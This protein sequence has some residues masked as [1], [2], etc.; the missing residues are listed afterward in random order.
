MSSIRKVASLA[1]VSVA[2]VS[3]ALSSPEKVS[4]KSLEKVQVAIEQ[5][6]YRPNMLAR[7]F[8]SARAYSIL[9]LIPDISNPFFSEVVRS[10]EDHAQR[11]GYG[12]LL[13]DTQDSK[14]KEQ[15]YITM[16]ETR[17]ADGVIQLR[18]D[19]P[20]PTSERDHISCVNAC[21][22][23]DTPEPVIRIDNVAAAKTLV[24]YLISLGH[25]RIGVI[26]GLAKNPHTKDRFAGYLQSLE[27]AGIEFDGSLVAEGDFT[28]WSGVNSADHFCRM[29]QRPTALFCMN[30]E[31]A[32]GAMQTLKSYNIDVPKEMSVT[33]FDDIKN[34]KYYN[35]S[36]TTIAQPAEE[37]G[38]VAVDTL[39]RII[40]GETLSETQIVLPFEFIVRNSTRP[41]KRF[42]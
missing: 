25:R 28:M 21:G 11:R 37:I 1:G 34:A 7:N 40:E 26:T 42:V 2:T 23:E 29:E 16:V 31:M 35:P 41:I 5:L 14:T 32:L 36:L 22:S 27:E 20:L 3:R 8:R 18:P 19:S 24:D 30:D 13:G 10:I 4:S 39:L 6:H 12:V 33:G 38:T 9:V 15:E 17:L